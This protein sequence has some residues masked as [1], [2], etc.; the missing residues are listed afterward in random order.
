[1]RRGKCTGR[2]YAGK[3]IL[4][5]GSEDLEVLTYRANYSAF[6]GYRWTASDYSEV[7]CR[8]CGKIWRTKAEYVDVLPMAEDA[9]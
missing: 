6:S 5:C 4:V 9:R 7:H 1:M 8:K 2:S 3:K